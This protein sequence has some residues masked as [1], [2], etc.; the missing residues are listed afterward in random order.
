M[1]L[2]WGLVAIAAAT[3]CATFSS[4]SDAPD[5]GPPDAGPSDGAVTPDA[6]ADDGGKQPDGAVPEG[7]VVIDKL[8]DATALAVSANDRVYWTEAS[9]GKVRYT[10]VGA[11]VARDFAVPA[12]DPMSIALAPGWVYWGDNGSNRGLYR[13]GEDG[14]DAGMWIAMS[15]GPLALG[16][17]TGSVV[18]LLASYEIVTVDAT[19]GTK[20]APV[21]VQNPFGVAARD[22]TY[23]W[24]ESIAHEV[25]QGSASNPTLKSISTTESGVESIAATPDDLFWTLNDGSVIQL[26]GGSRR[27]IAKEDASVIAVSS[28]RDNQAYWLAQTGE[29]RR[30]DGGKITTIAKGPPPAPAKHQA[31]PLA[32]T[33]SSVYWIAQHEILRAPR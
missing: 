28:D 23:F 16:T 31:A 5:A 8:G 12:G 26:A 14:A 19:T 13:A 6:P 17:P 32:L 24:T 7:V 11:G 30:F 33:P 18:C 9:E 15:S 10:D 22:A 21:G 25:W 20:T 2:R 3:A 1:R 27:V 4:S 29:V